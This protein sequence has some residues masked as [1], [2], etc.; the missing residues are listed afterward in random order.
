M[1]DNDNG[2]P[3]LPD[4]S[5]VLTKDEEEFVTGM[6]PCKTCRFFLHRHLGLP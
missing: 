1:A 6:P 5:K 2:K 3:K 4:L